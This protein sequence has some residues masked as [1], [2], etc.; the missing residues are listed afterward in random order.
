[1]SSGDKYYTAWTIVVLIK[2]I[3]HGLF[4]EQVRL[5]TICSFKGWIVNLVGRISPINIHPHQTKKNCS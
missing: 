3:N 2:D 1:M 5:E 4:I